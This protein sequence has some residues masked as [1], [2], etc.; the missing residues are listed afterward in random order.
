MV[1]S[2]HHVKYR[3]K[4]Q[5]VTHLA[6]EVLK[7]VQAALAAPDEYGPPR[8]ELGQQLGYTL[9]VSPALEVDELDAALY[10]EI[11]GTGDAL[12]GHLLP[13]RHLLLLLL[14]L[15]VLHVAV[16]V[17][18]LGLGNKSKM[19]QQEGDSCRNGNTRNAGTLKI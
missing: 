18:H 12:G 15:V 19:L 13:V 10:V 11:L 7:A 17:V 4:L 14:L 6:A 8:P 1:E 9:A 3:S 5:V 2:C 16:Q